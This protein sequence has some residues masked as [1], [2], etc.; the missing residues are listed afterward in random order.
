MKRAITTATRVASD[1]NGAGLGW[2]F[3]VLVPISGTPI[4]SGIPDPFPIPKIPV[5][6]F[7]IK[8]RC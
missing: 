3:R 4:G 7:L 2:E 8:F 1:D 5:G 6:K